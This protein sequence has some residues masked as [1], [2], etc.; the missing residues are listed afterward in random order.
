M[1]AWILVVPVKFCNLEWAELNL[2]SR[3]WVQGEGAA[4]RLTLVSAVETIT[5]HL[6]VVAG[7]PFLFL[8][9]F[10]V[11]VLHSFDPTLM[12]FGRQGPDNR[13]QAAAFGKI[14]TTSVRRLIS[15]I[16]R[17]SM[18]VEFNFLWCCRGSR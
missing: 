6:P 10:H 11:E 9:W 17:S 2:G 14:R 12:D 3:E 5:P 8:E 15:S 1:K 13:K 16:R 18:L 4:E 7:F